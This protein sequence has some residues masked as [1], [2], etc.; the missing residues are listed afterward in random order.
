M[1]NGEVRYNETAECGKYIISQL[2]ARQG[3]IKGKK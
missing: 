2:V 1:S 3:R